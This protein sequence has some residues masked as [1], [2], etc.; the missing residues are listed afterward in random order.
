MATSVKQSLVPQ[1]HRELA[2]SSADI[3]LAGSIQFKGSFHNSLPHMSVCLK[4]YFTISRSFYLL[5]SH[6][7]V[8]IFWE[9]SA[10]LASVK[11]SAT[12]ACVRMRLNPMKSQHHGTLFHF[13]PPCRTL[14][15]MIDVMR[16][17]PCDD[18]WS[19]WSD[20]SK[21]PC[22]IEDLKELLMSLNDR[23]PCEVR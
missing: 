8:L 17:A 5:L 16:V 23:P 20:H 1:S 9:F 11:G 4:M 22:D 2:S 19:W 13:E 14:M 21:V 12:Q 10:T 6:Q 3:C 15:R 7:S 18:L